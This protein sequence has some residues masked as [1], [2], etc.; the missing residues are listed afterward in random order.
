MAG[1][2]KHVHGFTA[3]TN[4]LVNSYKRLVPGYEAPP[5]Y[6]AW[7]AQNRSPLIRIPAARGL[8]TRIELRSVDPAANPYLAMT[9]ILASGLD[10]I[11]KDLT[12]PAAVDRNIYKMTAAD[13]ELNG[14]DSLPSSLEFA[15]IELEMDAIVRDALGDHIYDKFTAAKEIEWNKYRTRVHNWEREEYLTMY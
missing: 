4:P 11:R 6:V 12:P 1:I 14:I 3:I 13:R 15:L 7:S 5:C 2:M 9:V 10:G 8:S